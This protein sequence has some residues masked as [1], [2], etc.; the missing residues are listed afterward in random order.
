MAPKI[1]ATS[2]PAVIAPDGT[3]T[4]PLETMEVLVFYEGEENARV[5]TVPGRYTAAPDD[6]PRPE[7]VPGLREWK[8]GHGLFAFTGGVVIPHAELEET[9]QIVAR[10]LAQTARREIPV[11]IG[12]PE[13]G[14]VSL[15]PGGD[16][17]LGEEGYALD[18]GEV[19]T[20]TAPAPQGLLYGGTTVAQ[21][22]SLAADRRSIPQGLARDYPQYPVRAVML[23]IGRFFMPIEYLAEVTRYAA[24]F[25]LNEMH[26]HINDDSG[27]D[28]G[29]FRIECRTCPELNGN[30]PFYTYDEYRAFQKEARRYGV[31][32]VTEIDTPSHCAQVRRAHPELMLDNRHIDV[33]KPET[34]AF[35][36]SLY[37]EWLDGEDPVFQGKKFHIG[38]DEYPKGNAEDVR[39]YIDEL[40]TYVNGKGRETRLWASLGKMGFDGQTPVNTHA[41]AHLWSHGWGTL[42]DMVRDGY[43]IINNTDAPLYIVPEGAYNNYLNIVRLFD[44]WEVTDFW[45][46]HHMEK[47]H[48]QLLGAEAALWYDGKNGQSGFDIFDR[49]RDQIALMAEKTWFGD[50]AP[51]Q[52]GERF[53]A[54][55]EAVGRRAPLANPARYVE[56][57]GEMVADLDFAAAADG[58]VPDRSGNGYHAALHGLS[59]DQGALR[60]DGSGYL[61]LPFGSLGYPYTAA[62]ELFVEGDVPANALLFSGR[63]GALYLNYDG[64]GKIGYERKGYA[65]VF[66][67]VLPTGVWL[68]LMLTCS[69]ENQVLD[70]VLYVHGACMGRGVYYGNVGTLRQ[71]SSTFVLPVEQFGKGVRGAC[72]RLTLY[73][74][75]FSVSEAAGGSLRY[76]NLALHCPVTANAIEGG[77]NAEGVLVIP[78]YG[79]AMAVDGDRFTRVVFP[80]RED[81]ATLTVDLG[82]E[83]LLDRLLIRFAEMPN[84]YEILLSRDGDS[85]ECAAVRDGLPGGA[86]QK[87]AV[88]FSRPQSARYV[89]YHERERFTV[90]GNGA[91]SGYFYEIEIY[92]VERQAIRQRLDAAAQA[93]DKADGPTASLLRRSLRDAQAALESGP[94]DRLLYLASLLEGQAKEPA[95]GKIPADTAALYRLLPG[96][97][98]EDGPAARYARAVCCDP[99]ATQAEEDAARHLMEIQ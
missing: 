7:V 86:T 37:D 98:Q 46:G 83:C 87:D 55:F 3:K 36:K 73:N 9:A 22:L 92:G 82:E 91:Y 13:K 68:P 21:M 45:Y 35:I 67:F 71:E 89:R 18:I 39:R 33:S 28:D 38:T 30:A 60:L 59:A 63:D 79:P 99:C 40:I 84:S 20:V 56:S 6:N 47:G 31:D 75:A 49:F 4:T 53:A 93:A 48:P 12:S 32:V 50:K 29:S 52:T 95:A 10:Y 88:H 14:D 96:E 24:Y 5:E 69:S 19:L 11:R 16:A 77:V 26:I 58:M 25:K 57:G 65:Y 51:G 41:T 61:S 43:S 80:R 78:E 64:T 62:I 70:T 97:G 8:G 34:L 90:E 27:E 15:A 2:N 76:R 44:T 23:D 81:G 94:F 85:F 1:R 42:E 72:R 17:G 54:R 66:D 74:R